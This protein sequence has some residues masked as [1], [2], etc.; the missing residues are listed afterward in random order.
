MLEVGN[1]NQDFG[2]PTLTET[3]QR[4]HFSMWAAAKSPLVLGNDPRSMT[5]AT[6]SILGNAEVIDVN[7]DALG[8]PVKIVSRSRAPRALPS[9]GS[10]EELKLILQTCNDSDAFQHWS[11][12]G[13]AVAQVRSAG[14]EGYCAGVHNCVTRWPWWTSATPCSSATLDNGDDSS[15]ERQTAVVSPPPPPPCTPADQQR[16]M[17]NTT[18]ASGNRTTGTL[19]W[20]PVAKHS[21]C[22]GTPGSSARCCL[23]TEVSE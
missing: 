8:R 2:S 23:S 19:E 17:W 10:T 12:T 21:S 15:E 1:T 7:Q 11:I 4:A 9:E 16:W 13:G 3:E 14:L 22:W 18:K 20:A 6:L 5:N